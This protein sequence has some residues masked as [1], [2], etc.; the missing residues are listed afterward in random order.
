MY[1]ACR[2]VLPRVH[3]PMYIHTHTRVHLPM[4]NTHACASSYVYTHT[5]VPAGLALYIGTGIKGCTCNIPASQTRL[6]QNDIREGERREIYH[7]RVQSSVRG[8][9]Q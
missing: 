8:R 3:L 9:W 1:M 6:P 7:N 5:R 2:D 4:Y